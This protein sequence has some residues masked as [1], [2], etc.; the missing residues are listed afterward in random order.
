VAPLFETY[1]R[2]E[3]ED[4]GFMPD[5]WFIA[6]DGYE[7]VGV[8]S[9]SKQGEDFDVLESGLTG[10]RRGYRRRELATALKCRAIAF[11]RHLGALTIETFN[12]ENNPM[13]ALNQK[14]G[15]KAQ[16]AEVDWGKSVTDNVDKAV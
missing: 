13:F 2:R 14:L 8:A 6:L 15:F 11:A 4:P 12:E 3:F 16:P 1:A 5:G 7:L 9:L 10:V